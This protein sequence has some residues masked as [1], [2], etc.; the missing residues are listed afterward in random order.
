MREAFLD[1]VENRLKEDPETLAAYD[2]L[3]SE[4]MSSEEAK[5]CIANL[6]AQEIFTIMKEDRPYNDCDRE[7]YLLWLANLPNLPED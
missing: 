2:R 1:T 4:G 3:L 5:L 6:V 7:R